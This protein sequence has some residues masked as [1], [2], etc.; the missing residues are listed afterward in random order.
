MSNIKLFR[1]RRNVDIRLYAWADER[2]PAHLIAADWMPIRGIL[3]EEENRRDIRDR[4]DAQGYAMIE[5]RVEI[6][7][8]PS[9]VRA[10]RSK[11]SPIR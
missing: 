6:V 10:P 2:L 5:S 3:S 4:L 8:F 1:F 11:S 9:Q 7:D